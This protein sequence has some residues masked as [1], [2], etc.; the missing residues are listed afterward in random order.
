MVKVI[1]YKQGKTN[2]KS[3]IRIDLSHTVFSLVLSLDRSDLMTVLLVCWMAV[4]LGI[5]HRLLVLLQS[6]FVQD[7]D[8][9]FFFPP[10]P[11]AHKTSD[12]TLT[13]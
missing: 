10:S 4:G 3:I 1:E 2:I 7:G 13:N 11:R 5:F 6:C 9:V 8:C 12:Y